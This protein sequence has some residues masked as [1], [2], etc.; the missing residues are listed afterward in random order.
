MIAAPVYLH[1][2]PT[3]DQ[4]EQVRR[5]DAG[6]TVWT[7]AFPSELHQQSARLGLG[8]LWLTACPGGSVIAANL[9]EVWR[10]EATTG[11][12]LNLWPGEVWSAQGDA[13]VIVTDAPKGY[14]ALD[15]FWFRATVVRTAGEVNV[16]GA[17]RAR[18]T[19]SGFDVLGLRWL[20]EAL[21]LSLRDGCGLWAKTWAP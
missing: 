4:P 8:D 16:A 12:R 10:V 21:R 5:V 14:S 18:P 9:C 13:V 3:A 19:C 20:G 2:W 11:Q 15:T 1:S 7:F 17:V 6:Q